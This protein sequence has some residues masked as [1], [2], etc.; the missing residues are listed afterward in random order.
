VPYLVK[1]LKHPEESRRREA[2]ALLLKIGP[3]AREAVPTL[4]ELLEDPDYRLSAVR[5]LSRIGV[6]SEAAIDRIGEMLESA[7]VR[8]RPELYRILAGFGRA[9]DR[10][11]PRIRQQ[12]LSLPTSE[13]NRDFSVRVKS[14]L[15][16][17]KVVRGWSAEEF[18]PLV[19]DVRMFEC[20]YYPFDE[21]GKFL[22][23]LGP[24]AKTVVP[25]LLKWIGNPSVS[26]RKRLLI[27]RAIPATRVTL[28]RDAKE[29]IAAL[30]YKKKSI[31]MQYG[32]GPQ[33]MNWL[34][35]HLMVLDLMEGAL[36]ICWSETDRRR[37]HGLIRIPPPRRRE[38]Y[39]TYSKLER[40]VN[41]SLCA[42]APDGPASV[43]SSCCDKA[44]DGKA[45]D[46]CYHAK[47]DFEVIKPALVEMLED[48]S[49]ELEHRRVAL[50]M[51]KSEKV[52]LGDKTK[53]VARA[54][55][56]KSKEIENY[57][58]KKRGRI[59]LMRNAAPANLKNAI[60]T[61]FRDSAQKPPARDISIPSDTS[62]EE[63]KKYVEVTNCI[64]NRICAETGGP[65]RSIMQCC[66]QSWPEGVPDWCKGRY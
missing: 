20:K 58:W 27:A 59:R 61:C 47:P 12:M 29:L 22:T 31:D 46:W 66:K 50:H 55:T 63:L 41:N 33:M 45:P 3:A 4:V 53:A 28:A 57:R 5:T 17:L 60:E 40:C 51:L 14:A 30:E 64:N 10:L 21:A 39:L 8:A 42:R 26:W 1:W 56:R 6:P 34:S 52:E 2:I 32:P 65:T 35:R 7:S 18:L 16:L 19:L 9:A 15:E 25:D 13:C 44:W 48:P 24:R 37:R 38:D 49:V 43:I 11:L 62:N 54:V 36:E 23:R